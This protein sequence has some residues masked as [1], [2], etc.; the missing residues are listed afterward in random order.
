MLSWNGWGTRFCGQDDIFKSRSGFRA[1]DE[2]LRQAELGAEAALAA[3][4]L[5][6]IGL[7]VVAS[8]MEQAVED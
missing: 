3:G 8:E 2:A 6:C 5:A 7:M 4:H 1:F